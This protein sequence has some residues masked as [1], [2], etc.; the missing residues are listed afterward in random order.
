MSMSMRWLPRLVAAFVAVLGT[1]AFATPAVASAASFDVLYAHAS[2]TGA[3]AVRTTGNFSWLNRS[4]VL[5]NV[6]LY[7]AANHCAI[8]FYDGF[9]GTQLVGN[10]STDSMCAGPTGVWYN[11][12]TIT[13]D[14]SRVP[15]GITSVRV[16]VY[17]E[18][19]GNA[20]NWD[21]YYR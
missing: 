19:H 18:T 4:V 9:Q 1:V 21:W 6:R 17:D 10:D 8:A 12:G 3:T 20:T 15:G 7:V 14:G 5:N 11:F 13:L 16:Q 2:G